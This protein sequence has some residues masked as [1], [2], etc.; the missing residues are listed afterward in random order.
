MLVNKFVV[1]CSAVF[2]NIFGNN[3]FVEYE[4]N[5][6]FLFNA[7]N[8]YGSVQV[9][10]PCNGLKLFSLYLAYVLFYPF[11]SRKKR[12]VYSILGVLI[13][14]ILNVLRISSLYIIQDNYPEYLEFNHDYTFTYLMYLFIFSIWW[15]FSKKEKGLK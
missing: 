13:I 5:M 8:I 10:G 6:V 14:H 3:A 9:G 11:V 7:D 12:V 15:Y 1:N 2:L 4:S